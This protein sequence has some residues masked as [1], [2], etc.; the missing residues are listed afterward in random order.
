[1]EGWAGEELKEAKLGDKRLNRR[2][3][4]LVEAL[5]EQPSESVPQACGSWAATQAAYRFWDNDEVKVEAIRQAHVQGTEKRLEG[6]K[7][8]LVVQDTTELDWSQHRHTTG[9]GS[10]AAASHRGLHVHSALAVSEAGVPL[11]LVHQQVWQRDPASTGQAATRRSR[12]TQD[13]ESQRWLS[14]QA[15]SLKAVP[16]AVAVVTVADREADIYDLF[17]AKRRAGADLLVQAAQNRLVDDETRYLFSAIAARPIAGWVRVEVGR[18]ADQEPRA[19]LLSVRFTRLDLL[20]PRHHRQRSTLR[21]IRVQVILVEE[22]HPPEG[23]TALK[24][25][26]LTTL[27]IETLEPALECVRWY[28][29][30]W[31]IERYHFV[32]KSGCGLEQL[33]L[34]TADRLQRAL[35]TYS[36]VAWRLLWL[37]YLARR[38]PDLPC[39]LVLETHE[40]QALL[41][42]VHRTPTPP[43][44]S[45]SLAQAVRWIAQLGGFLARKGDGDPGVKTLWRGL[46]RLHD[47]AATWRL[48]HS[49]P[50]TPPP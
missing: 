39:T 37:T 45:P 46:A 8:V 20:P 10:L 35:A 17:A 11:G 44:S 6:E 24:W 15:A 28:A 1:M 31:L 7:R 33:Q 12:E 18:R 21:P 14:T 41:A 42:T 34:Q 48:A 49:S 47:I 9:L 40:W 13:K 30:R 32:L 2:L 19:A 26:L 38:S 36:L 43:D 16:E 22:D 3:V 4:K 23:C 5:A 25:L 29:S 50:P 27:P